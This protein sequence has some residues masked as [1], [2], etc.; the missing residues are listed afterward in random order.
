LITAEDVED[1]EN[2]LKDLTVDRVKSVSCG[3]T[4]FF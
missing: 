2:E 4:S 3:A 1:A